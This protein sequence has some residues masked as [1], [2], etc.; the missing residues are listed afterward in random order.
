MKVRS[1]KPESD[2]DREGF[3][4]RARILSLDGKPVEEMDATF[5]K[6][7]DLHRIFINRKRGDKLVVEL[8]DE[9]YQYP[10]T[11]TLVER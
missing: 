10:R 11:V 1:V 9:G 5:E 8:I 7:S 6:G 2:A 4:P 3:A